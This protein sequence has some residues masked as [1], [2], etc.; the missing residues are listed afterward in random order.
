MIPDN[1]G[2]YPPFIPNTTHIN[3]SDISKTTINNIN[4]HPPSLIGTFFITC[5]IIL[6]ICVLM[7]YISN[8]IL[9]YR[10]V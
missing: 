1:N 4:K 6:I 9:L 8:T 7:L 2:D 3:K 5:T 10:P